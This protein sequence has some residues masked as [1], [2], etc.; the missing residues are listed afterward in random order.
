MLYEQKLT[1]TVIPWPNAAHRKT[2]GIAI[3]PQVDEIAKALSDNECTA[4]Q[5][6]NC[7]EVVN[8]YGDAIELPYGCAIQEWVDAAKQ[9]KDHRG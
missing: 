6:N 2:A 8:K 1:G 9:L 4:K 7:Y 5:G 3:P